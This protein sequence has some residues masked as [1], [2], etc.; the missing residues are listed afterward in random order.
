MNKPFLSL[1][2]LI[3]VTAF[4]LTGCFSSKPTAEELIKGY[5]EK[6]TQSSSVQMKYEM[7]MPSMLGGMGVTPKM[8][9]SQ[10]VKNL[11][12]GKSL[13]HQEVD[14]KMEGVPMSMPGMEDLFKT[15]QLMGEDGVWMLK[16]VGEKKL[17]LNLKY[18]SEVQDTVMQM[19]EQAIARKNSAYTLTEADLDER[20]CYLVTE[21]V[22][23]KEALAEAQKMLGKLPGL[24][25]GGVTD[26]SEFVPVKIEYFFDQSDYL[27]YAVR[28]FNKAGDVVIELTFSD[29][30]VDVP[31]DDALFKVPGDYEQKVVENP[32][33][34]MST[35]MG[36]MS[37]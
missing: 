30:Q 6:M 5:H 35:M 2:F 20:K 37:P 23:E 12:D 7:T 10:Y 18:L 36:V 22:D 1:L 17:A 21:S 25:K 27:L 28:A 8:V 13:M 24:G 33:E 34:L 19:S 31:I 32:E 11:G 4:T 15:T 26:L 16:K 29:I 3:L 9:A 14:M